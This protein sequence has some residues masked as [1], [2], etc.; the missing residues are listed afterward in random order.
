MKFATRIRRWSTI[1]LPVVL[2]FVGTSGSLLVRFHALETWSQLKGLLTLACLLGAALALVLRMYEKSVSE[3]QRSQEELAALTSKEEQSRLLFEDAPIG[4]LELDLYGAVRRVNRAACRSLGYGPNEMLGRPIW[5]FMSSESQRAHQEQIANITSRQA[6]GPIE[7]EYVTKNGHAL[8]FEIHTRIIRGT[9]GEVA[10]IRIAQV[11]V[12]DR[13]RAERSLRDSLSL[14]QTTLEATTDGI[15]VVD[16]RGRIVSHNRRFQELWRLPELVLEAPLGEW[17]ELIAQQVSALQGLGTLV[18]EVKK[19]P[20]ENAK[21][22]LE[23]ADGRAI[24]VH[25]SPRRC[26]GAVVGTV[27]TFCDITAHRET[28]TKAQRSQDRWQSAWRASTDGLWEWDAQSNVVFLSPRCKQML[29]YAEDELPSRP[30]V[31]ESLIHPEDLDRVRQQLKD[32]VEQRTPSYVAEYRLRTR[33]GSYKWIQARGQALWDSEGRPIRM[34]GFHTDINERKLSE[35]TAAPEAARPDPIPSVSA[36][37]PEAGPLQEPAG[38]ASTATVQHPA[39]VV[40]QQPAVTAQQPPSQNGAL[41]ILLAEDNIINQK[42]A[43]AFLKVDGHRVVVASNGK[44]AVEK[45]LGNTFDVV[46]MDVQMP[47]MDGLEACA[48]IRLAEQATGRRTPIVAMTAHAMKG[49][50]EMCIAAGMDDYLTKPIDSA[51]LRR[52]L[53]KV[54]SGVTVSTV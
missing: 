14:L 49:D 36:V 39:A 16:P 2:L 23:L 29:G 26:D 15:L 12:S 28:L 41:R 37:P 6:V 43:T 25:S 18:A 20:E 38:K 24:E 48:A 8:P 51:A 17:H 5:D 21:A 30:G 34:V 9:Q 3:H 44:L 33:G 22:A 7:R 31:W 53:R 52:V 54:T 13:H 19:K 35:K 10:G 45:A 42:V 47:E 4:Y 1:T 27:W 11:D 50:R 32:H 46:L 40:T